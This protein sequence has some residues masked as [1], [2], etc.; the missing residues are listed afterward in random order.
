[1]GFYEINNKILNKNQGGLIYRFLS[2]KEEAIS[3]FLWQD[4]LKKEKF[5]FRINKF[6]ITYKN[7]SIEW[8]RKNNQLLYANI[9]EG[10]NPMK[11][12]KSPLMMMQEE[13]P[14]YFIDFIYEKLVKNKNDQLPELSF[15]IK[16]MK[17]YKNAN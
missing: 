6:Q 13:V 16:T 5:Y 1:M 3:V 17:K 10:D 2:E 9:D 7:Q 8:N 15:L 11:M 12:K 14:D 4:P